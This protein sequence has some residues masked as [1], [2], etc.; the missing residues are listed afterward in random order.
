[1]GTTTKPNPKKDQDK[2][3][4]VSNVSNKTSKDTEAESTA[5]TDS[6]KKEAT[7]KL[8]PTDKEDVQ[9][10]EGEQHAPSVPDPEIN[11]VSRE[12]KSLTLDLHDNTKEKEHFEEKPAKE[13]AD[14]NAENNIATEKQKEAA[15]VGLPERNT[16]NKRIITQEIDGK[17]QPFSVQS[18][19]D[20]ENEQKNSQTAVQPDPTSVADKSPIEKTIQKLNENAP[21]PDAIDPKDKEAKMDEKIV[22][23]LK[24]KHTG[25]YIKINDFLKSLYPAKKGNEPPVWD[26]QGES[27]RLRVLLDTM[28]SHG[29]IDIQGNRHSILG[30]THY[31]GVEHFA[32]PHTLNT[33][34]I[35]AKAI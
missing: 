28:K 8:K 15:S 19:E 29:M 11:K 3:E 34:D 20:Y 2:N 22:K 30:T 32:K 24:S 27:K 26:N 35:Y 13:K 9:G 25:E 5:T 14:I 10:T 12:D 6:K 4:P 16:E 18:K 7:P 1:M 17:E 23:F 33:T 31:V 21:E